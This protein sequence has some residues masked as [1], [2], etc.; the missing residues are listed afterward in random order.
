MITFT[1]EYYP[2]KEEII[3]LIQEDEGRYTQQTV[4]STFHDAITQINFTKK[5]I[6]S[7]IERFK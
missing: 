5:I 1:Y 3:K 7:N 2:T 4:Y 6:R